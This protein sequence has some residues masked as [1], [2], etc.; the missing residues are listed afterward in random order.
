MTAPKTLGERKRPKPRQHWYFQ[1][2]A[3]AAKEG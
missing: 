2:R 3:R 1:R